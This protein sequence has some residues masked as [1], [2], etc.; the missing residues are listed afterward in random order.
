MAIPPGLISAV[1]PLN[2]LGM[3]TPIQAKTIQAQTIMQPKYEVQWVFNNN[4][5]AKGISYGDF[6]SKGQSKGKVK[7]KVKTRILIYGHTMSF[8]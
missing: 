1:T 4:K 3:N 6:S 5:S 2:C 8:N 7:V